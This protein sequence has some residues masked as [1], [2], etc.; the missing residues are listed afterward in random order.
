MRGKTKQGEADK[1]EL[2]QKR[3]RRKPKSNRKTSTEFQEEERTLENTGLLACA[4]E[5]LTG[6][7]GLFGNLS[8]T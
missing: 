2:K 6:Y 8:A 7:E 5:T 3:R 1:E 4:V